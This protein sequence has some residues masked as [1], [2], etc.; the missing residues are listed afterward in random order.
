MGGPL[1]SMP[2]LEPSPFGS[3]R[4]PP[5]LTASASSEGVAEG[6]EAKAIPAQMR[7]FPHPLLIHL[8][9]GPLT[10]RGAGRWKTGEG[11]LRG[12]PDQEASAWILACAVP[13]EGGRVRPLRVF[14]VPS[15]GPL[16]RCFSCLPRHG[17]VDFL[18]V[19]CDP[20]PTH[21][22]FLSVSSKGLFLSYA[23]CSPYRC[24]SRVSTVI[25]HDG[26]RREGVSFPLLGHPSPVRW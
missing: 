1:E 11:A 10:G 26:Q 12:A 14:S 21:V 6:P 3:G 7:P 16:P 25:Q 8:W 22:Y 13:R 20:L 24:F 15:P 19:P 17:Q 4:C 2:R 5:C 18:S 9:E 23:S